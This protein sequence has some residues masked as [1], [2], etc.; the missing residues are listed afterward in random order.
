MYFL[1]FSFDF[2]FQF[3]FS[4]LLDISQS[5]PCPSPHRHH[6]PSHLFVLFFSFISSPKET[7]KI[8]RRSTFKSLVSRLTWMIDWLFDWSTGRPN[9]RSPFYA[10]WIVT[11]TFRERVSGEEEAAAATAPPPRRRA[12]SFFSVL[13]CLESSVVYSRLYYNKLL[14]FLVILTFLDPSVYRF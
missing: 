13:Y 14:W 10:S 7:R 6:F 11:H 9:E 3:F 12:F 1:L 8:K 5:G 2:L 4:F